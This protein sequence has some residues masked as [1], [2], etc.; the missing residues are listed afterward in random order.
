MRDLKR[1]GIRPP[2]VAVGDGALGFWSEVRDVW[3]KTR[4]SGDQG[5]LA[6]QSSRHWRAPARIS[7][8]K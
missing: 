1:R 4:G 5:V 3:P 8:T 2:V 6:Q 7:A